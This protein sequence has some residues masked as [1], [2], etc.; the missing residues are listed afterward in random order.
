MGPFPSEGD[1]VCKTF[2][3]SMDPRKEAIGVDFVMK[4]NAITLHTSW[5]TINID[6]MCNTFLWAL[7]SRTR[8]GGKW[9]CLENCIKW[10]SGLA[11]AHS[12]SLEMAYQDVW[13][14]L[15][16][17]DH[18]TSS[19][20]QQTRVAHQPASDVWSSRVSTLFKEGSEWAIWMVRWTLDCLPGSWA[21]EREWG[22]EIIWNP[23]KPGV[24]A[25]YLKLPSLQHN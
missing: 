6:I 19:Y 14:M 11:V 8:W 1:S 21:T 13:N 16:V 7:V 2:W 20:I 5:Y 12:H 24:V 25:C 17:F 10:L 18:F 22:K 15:W 23:D 3:P 9:V 4:N